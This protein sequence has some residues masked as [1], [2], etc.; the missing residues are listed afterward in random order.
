[1]KTNHQILLVIMTTY[2][3]WWRRQWVVTSVRSIL[4]S[5]RRSF[6]RSALC[7][8]KVTTSKIHLA[9]WKNPDKGTSLNGANNVKFIGNIALLVNGKLMNSLT[10]LTVE[11]KI[12]WSV[13]WNSWCFCY[14]G[15]WLITILYQM[16]YF[17]D[18]IMARSCHGADDKISVVIIIFVEWKNQC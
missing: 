9:K 6:Y 14:W 8:N 17:I 13:Y 7:V 3:C 1:M 16:K 18:D 10:G 12:Y 4:Q 2:C 15:S 11:K 5:V